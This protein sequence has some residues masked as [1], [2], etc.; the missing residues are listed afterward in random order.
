[1]SRMMKP[2][3]GAGHRH[4]LLT[5]ICGALLWSGCDADRGSRR[6][7]P[8][9][10]ADRVPMSTPEKSGTTTVTVTA[11]RPVTSV[12]G[13]KNGSTDDA[14]GSA[15]TD[16]DVIPE[17]PAERLERLKRELRA[18]IDLF[19]RDLDGP[20]DASALSEVMWLHRLNSPPGFL[21]EFRLW[22]RVPGRRQQLSPDQL[23][24]LREPEE[25]WTWVDGLN[26]S[27][28]ERADEVPVNESQTDK[29]HEG[30]TK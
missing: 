14:H 19:V 20:L 25:R 23:A 26:A 2:H 15:A 8:S 1:M 24:R 3:S 29:P 12:P 11:Q 22:L 18:D 27:L 13:G 9:A 5:V 4:P 10:A 6:G 30:E 16:V 17:T 28:S 21:R 7:A